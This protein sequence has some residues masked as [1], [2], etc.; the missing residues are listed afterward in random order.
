MSQRYEGDTIKLR[1]F[2]YHI[3]IGANVHS[4]I[5]VFGKYTKYDSAWIF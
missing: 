1:Q 3:M 5:E 2:F 4:A